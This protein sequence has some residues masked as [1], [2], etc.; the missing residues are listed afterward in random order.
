VL[1]TDLLPAGFEID[2]PS[3]VG[4][5][6]LSNFDWLGNTEVAHCEF[7]DDRF[8]AAFDRSGS[9]NGREMTLAYVGRA[10]TPGV[11]VLPAASVEDMYRPQ[12]SARTATGRMEVKAAR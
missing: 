7:R 2:N 3:L 4:S 12:F 5:A 11:Y 6:Q 10:E 1:V 9:S 8:V